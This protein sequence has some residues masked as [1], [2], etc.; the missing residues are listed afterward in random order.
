MGVMEY[1][2]FMRAN[3]YGSWYDTSR[4]GVWQ[5]KIPRGDAKIRDKAL[6]NQ[7]VNSKW[8]SIDRNPNGPN[9]GL[10]KLSIKR[11]KNKF[12]SKFIIPKNLVNKGQKI[13]NLFIYLKH[14]F[15]YS[16]T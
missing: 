2:L 3:Y 5:Y 4:F 16:F 8:F 14:Y 1:D 6:T 7:N 12:N 10:K 9:W 13:L 11:L 15:Y